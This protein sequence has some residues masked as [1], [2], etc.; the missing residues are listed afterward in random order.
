MNTQSLGRLFLIAAIVLV[1][2]G[3]GKKAGPSQD[4]QETEELP[5]L[6][7]NF[8][9]LTNRTIPPAPED[10][11]FSEAPNEGMEV[12]SEEDAKLISPILD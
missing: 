9:Y 11:S 6:E 4:P 7:Q 3:C 8:V 10:T 5:A 12:I 1:I 2:A